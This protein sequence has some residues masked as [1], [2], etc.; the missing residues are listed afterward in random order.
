MFSHKFNGPAWR[1]EI[2]FSIFGGDIVWANGPFRA[3]ESEIN[4]FKM[5]GGLRENMLPSEAIE[6]DGGYQGDWKLKNPSTAATRT[7]RGQ[8]SG[9]RARHK[10]ANGRLKQFS[11]LDQ[12]FRH[13]S[14]EQHGYCFMAVV[15]ITQMTFDLHDHLYDVNYDVVYHDMSV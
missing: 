2:G 13:L 12:V 15:V 4:I 9:I 7:E 5:E 6:C 8:K 11:C 10:I 14:S 3:G 1:Y